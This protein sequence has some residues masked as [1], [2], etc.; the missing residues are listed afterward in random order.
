MRG[1]DNKLAS[2]QTGDWDWELVWKMRFRA[3]QTTMAHKG[4]ETRLA[5]QRART[6]T[7]ENYMKVSR[8]GVKN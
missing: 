2:I 4:R 8:E 1:W 7:E 3:W 6:N 5:E